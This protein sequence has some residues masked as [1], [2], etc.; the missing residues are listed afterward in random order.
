MAVERWLVWLEPWSHRWAFVG[1]LFLA[2][3]L[4]VA[5]ATL[6]AP[7]EQILWMSFI[8]PTLS[9]LKYITTA[10]VSGFGKRKNVSATSFAVIAMM[11]VLIDVLFIWAALRSDGTDP[12]GALGFFAS[13]GYLIVLAPLGYILLRLTLLA[14]MPKKD[15]A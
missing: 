4:V 9:I 7:V 10:L 14:V 3:A 11:L 6:A 1:M 8:I 13:N 12:A 5:V 2:Q 15:R